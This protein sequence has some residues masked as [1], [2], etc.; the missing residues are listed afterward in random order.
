MS[1]QINTSRSSEQGFTLVELA[2]VM[3]IIGLL[4]GGVLKG[5]EL[6]T[7]ARITSTIAN[8]KSISAAI[9]TFQDKFSGLPGDIANPGTR[10]AACT[11]TCAT[12]G[13]A[14][15]QISG[16][17]GAAPAIGVEGVVGFA[18]LAA[19]DLISGSSSSSGTLI[20]VMPE[21]N[22]GGGQSG[23]M[24]LGSTD[25]TGAATNN[26]Q[27]LAANTAYAAIGTNAAVSGTSGSMNI[28]SLAQIDRKIDDGV[29]L[30][31][32]VHAVTS[33]GTTGGI[34]AAD[35]A[36]V[37]NENVTTAKAAA[38]IRVLN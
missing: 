21:I 26:L 27:P 29:P 36:A 25:A 28:T 31:G 35:V 22:T 7:N 33:T 24:W 1:L 10:L 34:S 15:G 2:I 3:V 23:F 38:Y 11:G 30:V 12:A 9:N 18:Q 13:N 19:A 8:I 17:P 5:Q 14:D 6:I 37:Y 4:I 32:S 20:E 16:V